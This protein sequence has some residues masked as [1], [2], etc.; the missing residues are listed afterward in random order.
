MAA[1]RNAFPKALKRLYDWLDTQLSGDTSVLSDAEIAFING[2]AATN[3]GTG[4]AV[5]LGTSGAL[6]L[7]G[8]VT[9]AALNIILD[10]TTGTKIGTSTSQKLAFWNKTPVIQQAHADQGA[11][12]LTAGAALAT[13]AAT[14]S[15]PYGFSQAQADGLIARVNAI[16]I[17]N[18]AINV[19][20]TRMRLDAVTIGTIKGSA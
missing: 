4:K 12:T 17:D 9:L 2:A 7:A 3:D 19:L 18:I 5:I 11:V 10:A 8:N 13:T 1:P 6:S 15:T 20:L 16:L 14:Q